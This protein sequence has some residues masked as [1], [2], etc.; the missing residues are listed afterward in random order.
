MAIPP[1]A[2]L[3]P[4]ASVATNIAKFLAAQDKLIED[5]SDE[6]D[7]LADETTAIIKSGKVQE[8]KQRLQQIVKARTLLADLEIIYNIEIAN[9]LNNADEVRDF[10]KKI[11]S[12]NKIL[13][14]GMAK[15][16][17]TIAVINNVNGF[18]Q[19]ADAMLKAA[20]AIAAVFA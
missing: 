18:L 6:D 15:V 3:P 16:N 2:E 4:V 1:K 12:A 10:Q 9:Q 7:R 5:L 19:T 8:Q 13:D 20:T 11:Q 14:G 17:A